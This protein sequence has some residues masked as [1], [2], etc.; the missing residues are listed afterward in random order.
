MPWKWLQSKRHKHYEDITNYS[1]LCTVIIFYESIFILPARLTSCPMQRRRLQN[2][3]WPHC[4]RHKG[5][6]LIKTCQ[7]DWYIYR[8]WNEFS[9]HTVFMKRVVCFISPSLWRGDIKHTTSFINTVWNENSFQIL[10]ITLLI[11]KNINISW[12]KYV[13]FR[14][15]RAKYALKRRALRDVIMLFL[16]TSLAKERETAVKRVM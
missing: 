9:F 10:F 13:F 6:V 12:K 5:A 3:L 14:K 16:M 11:P 1:I 2:T 8:I 7:T 15:F 4:K